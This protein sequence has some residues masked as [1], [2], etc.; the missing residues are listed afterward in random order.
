MKYFFFMDE[1]ASNFVRA[2]QQPAH[3]CINCIYFKTCGSAGRTE[4]CAGRVT[5]SEQKKEAKQK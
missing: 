4:P 2:N 3:P 5:K 1:F